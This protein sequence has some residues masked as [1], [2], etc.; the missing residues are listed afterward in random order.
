MVSL[1]NQARLLAAQEFNRRVIEQRIAAGK[2]KASDTVQRLDRLTGFVA[3]TAQRGGKG[4]VVGLTKT[5]SKTRLNTERLLKAEIK[6]QQELRAKETDL[7]R[8][9]K[10]ERAIVEGRITSQQLKKQI[11][12][13]KRKGLRA[14]PAQ[15]RALKALER[16]GSIQRLT[17]RAQRKKG[18]GIA[19]RNILSPQELLGIQASEAERAS[20]LGGGVFADPLFGFGG[21]TRREQIERGGTFGR[22]QGTI[23][24]SGAIG[25]G[26]SATQQINFVRGARQQSATARIG[27]AKDLLGG[28]L[29]GKSLAGAS[30]RQL[31]SVIDSSKPSA[32]PVKAARGA[33]SQIEFAPASFEKILRSGVKEFT[34]E[35]V[36]FTEKDVRRIREGRATQV[37]AR[38]AED[39]AKTAQARRDIARQ[40]RILQET[41][42]ISQR[43]RT[44]DDLQ[45][46]L[47]VELDLA[48]QARAER[49]FG[50]GLPRSAEGIQ[51]AGIQIVSGER[52]P[53]GKTLTPSQR[54]AK[55]RETQAETDALRGITSPEITRTFGREEVF[56]PSGAQQPI[57]ALTPAR[58]SISVRGQRITEPAPPRDDFF[59]NLFGGVS[60]AV[61]DAG[62]AL[63]GL[64]G[65]APLI[66][67]ESAG[68]R[69]GTREAVGEAFD[70]FGGGGLENIFGATE[71]LARGELIPATGGTGGI[72]TEPITLDDVLGDF[73]GR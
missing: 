35:A 36:P 54:L 48:N 3:K 2:L 7:E 15:K 64:F 24:P 59:G 49:E 34:T 46:S 18:R 62:S 56:R 1:T 51:V 61:G 66:E 58:E 41:G 68:I 39:V 55:A 25:V 13:R 8:F 72:Q 37:A 50:F 26:E 73:F 42:G 30:N 70:L 63:Q 53:K 12:A 52:V 9:L 14:T 38:K 21:R 11:A 65:G 28:N 60:E 10:N 67:S 57:P 40:K 47:G 29:F 16:A 44:L 69:I 4:R 22:R 20:A 43:G 33:R 6:R 71:S 45:R 23:L 32:D 27:F 31:L 19:G 17:A 5:K